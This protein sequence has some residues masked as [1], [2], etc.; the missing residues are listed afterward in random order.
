MVDIKCLICRESLEFPPYIDAD[1]YDGQLYCQSCQLLLDVK[2]VESKVR[3]Y[4]VADKQTKPRPSVIKVVSSIPRRD[5]SKEAE[6]D[7]KK[8][9]E[10]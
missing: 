6:G 2:L 5:Y 7:V 3:K 8:L 1:D 4:R 9:K 10:S